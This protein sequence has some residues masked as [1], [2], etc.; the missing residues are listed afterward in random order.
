MTTVYIAGPV[1]RGKSEEQDEAEEVGQL[2]KKIKKRLGEAGFEV[3]I[4][5]IEATLDQL[6]ATRFVESISDRIKQADYVV[7]ILGRENHSSAAES[8]VASFLE[9]R[10]VVMGRPG[11]R[12][13]RMIQGLPYVIASGSYKKIDDLL[14]MLVEEA[15]SQ[16]VGVGSPNSTPRTRY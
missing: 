7:T 14:N 6:E 5:A 16:A 1:F 9:K 15:S 3:K 13:P 12:L 10:Q 11:K 4:P 8:V 2:Y